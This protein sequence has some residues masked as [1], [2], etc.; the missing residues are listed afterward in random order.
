MHCTKSSTHWP[1]TEK[2]ANFWAL[3]GSEALD[4]WHWNCNPRHRCWIAK[5]SQQWNYD[6]WFSTAIRNNKNYKNYKNYKNKNYKNKNKNNNNNN[7]NNNVEQST[8]SKSK[9]HVAI[10]LYVSG[11]AVLKFSP[12]WTLEND[13][14]RKTE[15]F[16]HAENFVCSGHHGICLTI[17]PRV[18]KMRDA[19]GK[20][21]LQSLH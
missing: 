16:W 19:I 5:F 11:N 14:H 8:C 10:C 4:P 13:A 17:D 3:W 18:C 15:Q 7:N 1:W 20:P 12:G 21:P 9:D 6:H 2:S